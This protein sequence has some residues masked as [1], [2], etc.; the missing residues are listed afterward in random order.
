[1]QPA[2]FNVN[3]FIP[4][5]RPSF[6][7]ATAAAVNVVHFSLSSLRFNASCI[8]FCRRFSFSSQFI[9]FHVLA[10]GEERMR[11]KQTELI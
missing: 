3:L 4:V 6:I 11:R 1:M 2:I 5:E 10:E 8:G 9:A 7:A